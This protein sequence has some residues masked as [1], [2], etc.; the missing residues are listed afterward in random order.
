MNPRFVKNLWLAFGLTTAACTSATA[1]RL[2]YEGHS[3]VVST[4]P[5]VVDAVVTLRNIGSTTAHVSP[6]VCPLAITAFG[7]AERNEEPLW[8]SGSDT[9]ISSLMIY[10]PI[11][12]APGDFYEYEVTATLPSTLAGKRVF[13]SMLVPSAGLVPIGQ[14]VVK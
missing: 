9:C 8:Q 6:P 2:N 4:T 10:P 7:S 1:P 13:L 11:I 3:S 14:L 12:I 5:T